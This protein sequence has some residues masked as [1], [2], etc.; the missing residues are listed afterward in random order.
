MGGTVDSYYV[1]LNLFL[2]GDHY[3]AD[4]C[5][6]NFARYS[7]TEAYSTLMNKFSELCMKV[8]QF[9]LGRARA[10]CISVTSAGNFQNSVRRVE[11]FNSLVMLVKEN[12][13][14]CNWMD[15]RLLEVIAVSTQNRN[16]INLIEGFKKS[17]YSRTLKQVFND[18]PT[19]KKK[20]PEYK[21]L[22]PT[23]QFKNPDD[24]KVEELLAISKY[25][26][27]EVLAP[28]KEQVRGKLSD[29]DEN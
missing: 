17:V 11:S 13:M 29:T 7:V 5:D 19:L 4:H 18:I 3:M 24:M 22:I 20:F 15:I 23:S 16:L 27:I 14:Y 10:A 6:I 12:P 28:H 1:L 9:D 21:D 25:L 2:D 26:P 8:P